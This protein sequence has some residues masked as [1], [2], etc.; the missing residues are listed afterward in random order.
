M[1]HFITHRSVCCNSFKRSIFRLIC[2]SGLTAIVSVKM[3]D[4]ANQIKEG[5]L[6][7]SYEFHCHN[8]DSERVKGKMYERL[9]I[10]DILIHVIHN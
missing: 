4:L 7:C 9:L 6:Y 10:F 8:Y 1:L 5:G 3:T 2:H